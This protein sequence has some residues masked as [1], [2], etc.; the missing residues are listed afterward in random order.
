MSPLTALLP[1]AASAATS[2]A[3][4]AAHG[5]AEGVSFAAELATGNREASSAA[6]SETSALSLPADLREAIDRFAEVIR[7]RLASAGIDLAEPVALTGDGLGGLEIADHRQ[8]ET[9]ESLLAGDAGIAD[10]F[11]QLAARFQ[12][13]MVGPDPAMSSLPWDQSS[14]GRNVTI[15][16]GPDSA[17]AAIK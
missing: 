6:V 17:Q 14:A 16:I 8:A 1:A 7:Q 15:E 12:T 9:I 5:I 10:A 13:A 11:H 2:L 3:K 4:S